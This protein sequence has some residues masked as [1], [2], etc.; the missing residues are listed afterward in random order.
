LLK[1]NSKIP[2]FELNE[3]VR[4]NGKFENNNIRINLIPQ[5]SSARMAFEG[6]GGKSVSDVDSE[7]LKERGMVIDATCVRVMKARKVETHN[8]LVASII[9]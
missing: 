4:L 9:R 1:E 8:E 6:A 7:V 2:K 3:K 5:A